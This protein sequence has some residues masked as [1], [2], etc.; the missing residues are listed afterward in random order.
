MEHNAEG[1]EFGSGNAEVG[2]EKSEGIAQ[3]AKDERA[4]E[5]ILEAGCALDDE[6]AKL[7][8]KIKVTCQGDP[9]AVKNRSH[10]HST[11]SP[12]ITKFAF[13]LS[14]MSFEPSAVS[15]ELARQGTS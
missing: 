6:I 15:Y 3:R 12:G 2:K 7:A 13:L 14:A 4:W 1:F 10:T 11:C 5:D 9:I 8:A